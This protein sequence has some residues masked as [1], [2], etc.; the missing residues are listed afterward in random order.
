MK[1]RCGYG[2]LFLVIMAATIANALNGLVQMESMKPRRTFVN[3]GRSPSDHIHQVVFALKQN[4]LDIL[5]KIILDRATPGN[6]LYQQWLTFDE[7]GS[8]IKNDAATTFVKNWLSSMSSIS[9]EWSSRRG[10]YVRASAPIS[11]WEA[12]FNTQFYQW[13]DST[14]DNSQIVHRCNTY[15]LTPEAVEHITSV[16]YTSQALPVIRKHLQRVTKPEEGGL[17]SQPSIVNPHITEVDTILLRGVHR[18]KDV[19]LT[20]NPAPVTVSFLNSY[21]DIASNFGDASQGISVFETEF[22]SFSQADLTQFQQTYDLTRQS[23][24]I[25][26]GQGETSSCTSS[27][28]LEGNLDIQYI[29]GISQRTAATYW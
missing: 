13:E 27:N 23:A 17:L 25:V 19:T 22:E 6:P 20:S 14:L 29:M 21:Y 10:E 4:N 8:Y 18:Q 1:I 9:I 2:L 16:F 24:L 26:N 15:F 3:V 28:C 7:V 11:T 12:M 5:E